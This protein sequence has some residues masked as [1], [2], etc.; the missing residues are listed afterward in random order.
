MAH[1]PKQGHNN[2]LDSVALNY[3]CP[4]SRLR[5]VSHNRTKCRENKTCEQNY[6]LSITPMQVYNTPLGSRMGIGRPLWGPGCPPSTF[7]M[8]MVGAPRSL[9]LAPPRGA[10]VDVF[11]VDSGRSQ[12]PSSDTSQGG[13]RRRFLASMVDALGSPAPAPPRRST[14]DVFYVIGGCSRI[15]VRTRQGAHHQCFFALMV[16]ALGSLAPLPRGLTANVLQLSGS[17]SHTSS[18]TS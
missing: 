9:A 17:H 18:N 16:D 13:H 7:F 14:V 10:V 11:S 2:N 12:I 5:V 3:P 8:L 4:V 6:F 1:A 15:S